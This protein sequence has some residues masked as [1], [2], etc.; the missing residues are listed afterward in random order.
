MA[1]LVNNKMHI[2]V[3]ENGVSNVHGIRCSATGAVNGDGYR[4]FRMACEYCFEL[5]TS[6]FIDQ[7]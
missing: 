4:I 2:S 6:I 1:K 7:A 5:S 3:A